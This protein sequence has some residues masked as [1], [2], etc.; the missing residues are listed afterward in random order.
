MPAA[1]PGQAP[2]APLSPLAPTSPPSIFFTGHDV[3]ENALQ[4]TVGAGLAVIAC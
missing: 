1:G 4:A 3:L 2:C